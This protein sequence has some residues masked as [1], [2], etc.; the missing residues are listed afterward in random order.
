MA[1]YQRAKA[2]GFNTRSWSS[3]A[4][5]H[6]F[7][8]T[9]ATLRAAKAAEDGESSQAVSFA[10]KTALLS[11]AENEFGLTLAWSFEWL[12]HTGEAFE[13]ETCSAALVA[14]QG[15]GGGVT[16]HG[17][18]GWKHSKLGETL[19]IWALG[20]EWSLNER[21]GLLTEIH[22]EQRRK[23]S[24]GLGLRWSPSGEWSFGLMA[25]HSRDKPAALNGLLI[26]TKLAF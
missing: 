10:G 5:C 24:L 8:G 26:T 25:S 19:K 9:Q 4:G 3:E 2:A 23:S 18:L 6:A 20:A 17:N 15:L 21:V 14:S 16:A 12:K 22:G 11:R 7:Y 1:G 13:F